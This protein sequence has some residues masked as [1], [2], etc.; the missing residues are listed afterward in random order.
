[1]KSESEWVKERL[2]T[3]GVAIIERVRNVDKLYIMVTEKVYDGCE[4]IDLLSQYSMT[5]LLQNRFMDNLVVNFAQGKYETSWFMRTSLLYRF[6]YMQILTCRTRGK[7][8][9]NTVRDITPKDIF[10]N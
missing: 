6:L 5:A 7:Q 1:V 4:T 2:N 8:F 10:F 3:I 9:K